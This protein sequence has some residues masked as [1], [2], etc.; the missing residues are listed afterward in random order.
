M[1][2]NAAASGDE[3]SLEFTPTW[4]LA[5]V[6]S[7][8]VIISFVV[9]RSLHGLGGYLHRTKRKSLYHALQ[10]VKDELMLVGFISLTLTILQD[11]I[12]RICIRSSLYT[13]WS[14]CKMPVAEHDVAEG[15]N[16][17]SKWP[18]PSDFTFATEQS[19]GRRR[20]LASAPSGSVCPEGHE[21]FLSAQGLH[22]LHIFIFVLAAAH[23][24]YSCITMALA[25]A[26]VHS[27]H[28][29]E[30]AA[31][32]ET[33]PDG[34][35]ELVV[36]NISYTRQ[37]TFMRYHTSKPWSRSRFIVWVVCFFQQFHIPR[38]DYLTLRFSFITTHNLPH[39]YNFH[40][41]MIRSME[42]EFETIV[43]ISAWLWVF[44]ISFLLFN[45]HGVN[46][47]F[48]SSF[49]PVVVILAIG[50]KL[51]HIVAT[52][53][54]ESTG[55]LPFP[56][57]FMGAQL[58][59]RDQLFW[60][61]RPKLLLH[62]IHL[63][64]FQNAFEFA[65]FIWQVWQFGFRSCLLEENKAFVYTRLSIGLLVQFICS[66]STLPLYALVSQMGTNFKKAVVP[67]KVNQVL[68][69]WHK[70]AKKR[71]KQGSQVSASDRDEMIPKNLSDR[72][73][74]SSGS[75][76]VP[77]TS[78]ETAAMEEGDASR[79]KSRKQTPMVLNQEAQHPSRQPRMYGTDGFGIQTL[80]DAS[81]L[82]V[83]SIVKKFRLWTV[84]NQSMD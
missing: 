8:F 65:T 37:S 27:W 22:Q 28:K 1:A 6:S 83:R 31:H 13:K 32:E 74:V 80:A 29:W 15:S 59:P 49:V 45:V 9:E 23:V 58:K 76:G 64:L 5:T 10:K 46:L 7:V 39:L 73:S 84:R 48:W 18:R 66:Y 72:K 42:D 69:I 44:V 24:V 3:R 67:P 78:P 11:S 56:A 75:E 21:S 25:L 16:K 41:Y 79:Y 61:N 19:H 35:A 40:K 54:M 77:M 2:G 20:L 14:P 50:M 33:S 81:R 34:M 63:I 17:F 36:N 71:L 30:A 51:Q 55:V 12:E 26:K 57:P 47:Y 43:G 52:L 38:A 68:H 60:F 70:D 53:A 4:A 62:V 82:F